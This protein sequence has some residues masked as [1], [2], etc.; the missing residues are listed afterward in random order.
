MARRCVLLLVALGGAFARKEI[1]LNKLDKEYRADDDDAAW[2][3]A[4]QK[5]RRE[6]AK[7]A[8]PG[9]GFPGTGAP[10]ETIS[11]DVMQEMIARAKAN[12]KFTQGGT[13]GLGAAPPPTDDDDDDDG[14]DAAKLPFDAEPD[15]VWKDADNSMKLMSA[16][17]RDGE[18]GDVAC[19]AEATRLFVALLRTG[20]V[21]QLMPKCMAPNELLLVLQGSS[22]I[23]QMGQI[24]DFFLERPEIGF[25]QHGGTRHYPNGTTGPIPPPTP[26]PAPPK[27]KKRRKKK[28]AEAPDL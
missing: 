4:A 28:K 20:G 23:S 18:C 3:T 12:G 5:R 22:Q 9:A 1:D 17:L 13:G 16:F 24:T 26:R 6:A 14:D 19:C 21:T 27:K 10:G 25:V 8:A 15:G 11:N 7:A 2:E